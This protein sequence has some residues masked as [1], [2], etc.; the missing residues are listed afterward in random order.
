VRYPVSDSGSQLHNGR[1]TD[2]NPAQ[3]IPPSVD[4]AAHMN[5]VYDELMA[6]IAAGGL[7]PNEATLTQV[8]QAIQTLIAN[9]IATRAPSTHGHLWSQISGI[10]ATFPPAP[11]NQDWGTI[12]GVPAVFPPAAHNQD[13]S[14]ITGRPATFPPS[15]HDHA[16][17]PNAGNA[18]TVDGYH[19]AQLWRAD[20][21]WAWGDDNNGGFVLPNGRSEQWGQIAIGDIPQD[22]F[23][24]WT[25]PAAF[26]VGTV[27]KVGVTIQVPSFGGLDASAAT[28]NPTNA[29]CGFTL[30]E[31]AGQTQNFTAQFRASGR[32]W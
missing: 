8:L 9:A 24:S 25:Y 29:S 16:Y 3:G 12:T 28:I 2:G 13:W 20:Q 21:S 26:L 15:V 1:F 18:D 31:W 14:T 27:P 6:V 17:V 11:H 22:Y 5:A 32:M 23:G 10:P 30:Q 19:A 7:T 4:K